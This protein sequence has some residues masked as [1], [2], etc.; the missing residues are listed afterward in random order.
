[1]KSTSLIKEYVI[2]KNYIYKN[3]Y[4]ELKEL[5]KEHEKIHIVTSPQFVPYTFQVAKEL[6]SDGLSTYDEDLKIERDFKSSKRKTKIYI[7]IKRKP[8]IFEY[9]IGKEYYHKSI[10]TEIKN[11]LNHH[12]K[13]KIVAKT[14]E[15]GIAFKVASELVKKGIAYYDEEL[16][17]D[18]NFKEGQGKTNV[19]ISLK[20]R[21]KIKS[22]KEEPK[23]DVSNVKT[24]K[25]KS[26]T[27]NESQN[28]EKV[29]TIKELEIKKNSSY[30]KVVSNIRDLLNGSNKIKLIV[31]NNSVSLAFTAVEA[32]IRNKEIA[33]D[34]EL[35]VKHDIQKGKGRA[36]IFIAI[37][38]KI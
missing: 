2:D 26:N 33:Y 29:E 4:Q 20:K 11:H 9:L 37:K 24:I 12:N 31:F 35:F 1:M 22:I 18:R 19:V 7:S 21:T 32:L 6:Y 25:P 15:V 5:L 38:K 3:T 36:K 28:K 10:Y 16:K 34:E 23:K 14:G 8:K 17:L 27:I 30:D 13:V